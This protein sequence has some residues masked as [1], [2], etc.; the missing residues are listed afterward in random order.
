MGTILENPEH[1]LAGK[2]IMYTKPIKVEEPGNA[3][4]IKKSKLIVSN[5]WVYS[6][7]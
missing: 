2:T 3:I 7:T 4:L 6:I 1:A 5:I